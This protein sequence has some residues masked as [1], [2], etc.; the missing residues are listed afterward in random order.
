MG[1]GADW[2]RRHRH[3]KNGRID[4]ED[5]VSVTHGMDDPLGVMHDK[6]WTAPN[7]SAYL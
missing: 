7:G 1:G 3:P 5:A 2:L 6:P 4:I